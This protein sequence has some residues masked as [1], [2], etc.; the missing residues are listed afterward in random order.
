MAMAEKAQLGAC[1]GE[2]LQNNDNDDSMSSGSVMSD[3]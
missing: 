1:Y 3:V 2:T